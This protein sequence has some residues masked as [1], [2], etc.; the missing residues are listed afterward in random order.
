[1]L[2]KGKKINKEFT[3]PK[4]PTIQVHGEIFATPLFFKGATNPR[5]SSC[6][7]YVFYRN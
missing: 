3:V 4:R 5:R 6:N 7:E 2:M 1:M